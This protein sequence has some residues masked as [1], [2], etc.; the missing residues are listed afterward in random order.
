[1]REAASIGTPLRKKSKLMK[2]FTEYLLSPNAWVG[3]CSI[4][5][6]LGLL[7]CAVGFLAQ[8]RQCMLIGLSLTT[9]ILV[10]G[11]VL[12][13]VVFPL[14]MLANRKHRK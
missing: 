14:L 9:P 4:L 7:L 3:A 12:L 1:M 5:A 8:N 11:I 13:L 10:G 6:V 2:G